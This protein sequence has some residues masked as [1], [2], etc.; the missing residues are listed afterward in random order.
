MKVVILCGGKGTR[1]RE[2][3]VVKPKPLVK[4]GQYP[5]LW[6]IMKIYAHYGF[7]EFVLALGYKGEMIKE[8]FLNYEA[9]NNDFTIHL[10]KMNNIEFHSKHRESDWIVTLADTGENA[11]TGSRIKR[12]ERYVDG[13]IFMATYGDGVADINISKLLEFHKSHKKIGTITGVRPPS[14]FGELGI[15]DKKIVRFHEKPQVMEGWIN[16]GYFVFNRKFFNYLWEDD[17]CILEE[18]PLEKLTR[19]GELMFFPHRGFWQCVDTYRELEILNK[20]WVSGS[21]PWKMW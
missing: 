12:I 20:M 17:D 3:T 18:G 9:L 8:Y 2:E 21:A 5:I 11:Q 19:D 4:I 10:G 1:L 15:R 7:K 13:E 14:R 16:G 6:H